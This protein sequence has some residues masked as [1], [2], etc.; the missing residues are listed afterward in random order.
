MQ[1]PYFLMSG[2]Y[3]LLTALVTLD[4]SLASMG[5]APAFANLKWMRVHFVT[6]GVFTQLVLGLLPALTAKGLHLPKPRITWLT[7]LLFNG[8]L[9][10]LLVGLPVVDRTMI[11]TGGTL[12]FAAVVNLMRELVFLRRTAVAYDG[13]EACS[14]YATTRFYLAGLFYLLVGVLV[15]TGLWIGWA[16]PL[17]IAIPK[18]VHV[19]TN[20]WGYTS[21]VFAGL[22]F[23]IFPALGRF[24]LV[25]KKPGRLRTDLLVFASMALGALGLV[26]GPWLD[27]S[28]SSVAG[29]SL[30][31][32]GTLLLLVQLVRLLAAEG[33][34]RHAAEWHLVS[35]YAWFLIPV[36][37][38]PFIV[39]KASARFPVGEVAGKGGPILVYGWLLTFLAPLILY[40]FKGAMQPEQK[41][42]IRGSWRS[43]AFMHLG[44]LLF[45]AGLFLPNQQAVMHAGAY[46][47]WLAG[48]MPVLSSLYVQTRDGAE[49][50]EDLVRH[51]LLSSEVSPGGK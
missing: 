22:L 28:W 13:H 6:L 32:F 27:W 12:I 35:A 10:L 20:L 15:G 46:L 19:H 1:L 47:F 44:S 33:R 40:F 26:L 42:E 7:W 5:W 21:L 9:V 23:D 24:P 37:V 18:E 8:G 16:G 51:S 50:L 31:T 41:A 17:H 30:H 11:I 2:M 48:I 34:L 4:S 14:R 36:V 38:A 25:G 39:A 3:L 49:K 45:W 29:L 43:L